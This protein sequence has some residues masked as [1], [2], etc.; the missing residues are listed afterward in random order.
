MTTKVANGYLAASGECVCFLSHIL[1]EGQFIKGSSQS[2]SQVGRLLFNTL[3]PNFMHATSLH[4]PIV[5]IKHFIAHY[6]EACGAGIFQVLAH[7]CQ[8]H[9]E[10]HACRILVILTPLHQILRQILRH[11]RPQAKVRAPILRRPLLQR[12][13]LLLLARAPPVPQ[14]TRQSCPLAARPVAVTAHPTLKKTA[15]TTAMSLQG[16]QL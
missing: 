5:D 3:K 13:L 14:A 6:C 7:E 15:W 16:W 12:L 4:T 9:A 1:S 2:A 10:Y 8:Q 11:S